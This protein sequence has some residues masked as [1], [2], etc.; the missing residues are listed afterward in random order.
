MIRLPLVSSALRPSLAAVFTSLPATHVRGQMSEGSG[1]GIWRTGR[2]HRLAF[3]SS[4]I[5][6]LTSDRGL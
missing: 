3:L 5:R 1:I 4:D 2:A 6:H